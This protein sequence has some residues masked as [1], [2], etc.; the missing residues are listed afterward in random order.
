M[1]IGL[2]R[3]QLEYSIIPVKM[4]YLISI[5]SFWSVFETSEAGFLFS[6]YLFMLPGSLYFGFKARV[7]LP[8]A[9]MDYI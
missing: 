1:Q 5:N 4:L 6:K 2:E 8:Q 3:M 9:I 7:I